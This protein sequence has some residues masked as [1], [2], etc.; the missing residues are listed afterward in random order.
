MREH[1]DIPQAKENRT[2]S[3]LQVPFSLYACKIPEMYANVPAHW[4]EEFELNCIREGEGHFLLNGERLPAAAGDVFLLPPNTLHAAYARDGG[5]LH[6]EAFVF[7]PSLV[8][9]SGGDRSA[10]DCI[11]P[12]ARGDLPVER[13]IPCGQGSHGE[14]LACA[15]RVFAAARRNTARA[16]LLLK[17]ELFRLLYLLSQGAPEPAPSR[18]EGFDAGLIREA[19]RCMAAHYAEDLTIERLA[20]CCNLSRSYFMFC[21]KRATG[22]SAVEHLNRLRVRAACEALRGTNDRV[23]DIAA[24]CGFNNL[25]NF[26]RQFKRLV[27]CS[28]LEYRRSMRLLS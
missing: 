14:I 13:R 11:L 26:N 15:E 17:S 2:H 9:A 18:A 4:H 10:Q 5:A 6:Y 23:A 25:S 21:F 27:G 7:H 20:A 12:L 19:L 28:P 1:F 22:L 24:G 3:T 16:D 8:G